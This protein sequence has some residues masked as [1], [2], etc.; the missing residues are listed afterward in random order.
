MKISKRQIRQAARES[1]AYPEALVPVHIPPGLAASNPFQTGSI[2]M[3]AWRSRR[4]LVVLWIESNGARRLS[5]MRT[6]FDRN[7]VQ[8]DGISW[9]D[10]QRLKSEAGFHDEC[11]V[12][13]YPPDAHVV[14]VANMR[15]LFLLAEPPA[16]MWGN[17]NGGNAPP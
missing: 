10:L 15:H 14:N 8:L 2:P 3:Q 12:E 7:G 9:D 4:F 16:F 5:I 6:E 11:A 17:S 13:L 1:A